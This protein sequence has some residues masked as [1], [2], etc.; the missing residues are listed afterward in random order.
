MIEG[1]DV[2]T[3]ALTNLM[4]GV[5]LGLGL[6]IFSRA[7]PSFKGFRQ[8]GRGYLLLAFSFLLIGLREYISDW[9]SIVAANTLLLISIAMLCGGLLSFFN[10]NR[11]TFI[12]LSSM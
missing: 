7:H 11:K 8:L 12:Q 2:R 1:F 3:L 6:L 5:V 10:I 9:F 4:L